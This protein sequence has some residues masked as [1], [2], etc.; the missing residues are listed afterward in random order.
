MGRVLMMVCTGVGLGVVFGIMIAEV[1]SVPLASVARVPAGFSEE[2]V[3]CAPEVSTAG[4]TV[5]RSKTF[6]FELKFPPSFTVRE[7]KEGLELR[8]VDG[9][10]PIISFRK[11]RQTLGQA[12]NGMPFQFAG[13]KV[14]DR[15][16]LVLSTPY[17]SENADIITSS[18]LFLREFQLTGNGAPLTVMHAV[19]R[20]RAM[21]DTLLAARERG[22]ADIESV[23]T[24]AEQILST[25]RF[26]TNS[27]L[28][29][30]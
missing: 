19:I 29:G 28:Y 16:N 7:R 5:F 8:P 25:F 27:E 1:V 2:I 6:A 20:D 22:I 11:D 12:M 24:P 3:Q 30:T 15:Q 26:L 9:D 18:Y 23:L 13:Y 4:W 21:N 14:H 17:F 10:F